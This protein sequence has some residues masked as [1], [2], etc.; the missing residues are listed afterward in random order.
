M[1]VTWGQVCGWRLSQQYVSRPGDDPVAV[2]SVLGGMQAQVTSSAQLSVGLRST[3]TPEQLDDAL[4]SQR[5]LVKTWAMR[6]TLHWLPADE[7]PLWIAALR[8]R[9]WRIT[10]GWEKYHGVTMPSPT[11]SPPPWRVGR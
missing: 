5:R 2:V 1:S 3:A 10:P 4:W 8:T 9:E 7:Y 6:G 11:P